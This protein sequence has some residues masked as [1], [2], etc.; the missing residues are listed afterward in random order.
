MNDP[1]T[2]H[3][4]LYANVNPVNRVDPTGLFSLISI[5]ISISIDLNIQ[6]NFA[7]AG[8][9]AIVVV[10]EA[11]APLIEAGYRLQDS[12]LRAIVDGAPGGF[13]LYDLGRQVEYLGWRSVQKAIV[14]IYIDTL[15][16][17]LPKFKVKIGGAVGA[18]I[19][20]YKKLE[21]LQGAFDEFHT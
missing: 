21:S 19:S 16:S 15:K 8:L 13:D 10:R 4:Y 18:A 11:S 20:L 12:G 17:L 3:K 1:V 9:K 14:Q 5:S 2:L 6:W 7:K